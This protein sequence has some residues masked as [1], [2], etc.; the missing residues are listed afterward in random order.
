M[1]R[2]FIVVCVTFTLYIM[3]SQSCGVYRTS[4]TPWSSITSRTTT[5]CL[6]R[7]RCVEF[8]DVFNSSVSLFRTCALYLSGSC[9]LFNEL[10]MDSV[11]AL[12]ESKLQTVSGEVTNR[13][14][15]RNRSIEFFCRYLLQG[16]SLRGANR[17]CSEVTCDEQ[18]I[19]RPCSGYCRSLFQR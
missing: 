16:C 13:C 2:Y 4:D 14:N 7:R 18:M 5:P 9:I 6:S 15:C 3:G 12:F 17:T 1:T 19:E 11:S 8:D 10:Q